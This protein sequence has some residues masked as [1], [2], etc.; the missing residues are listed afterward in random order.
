MAG[1]C[2]SK[3]FPAQ[4]ARLVPLRSG[5]ATH[6]QAVQ[7]APHARLADL[8]VVVALEVYLDLA[9]SEVVALP[10]VDDLLDD[11]DAGGV[12]LGPA[13]LGLVEQAVDAVG[14]IAAEPGV[15]D[16]AADADV[17]AGHGHVPGDFLDVTQY[18][19]AAHLAVRPGLTH[20]QL[21]LIKKP[22]RQASPSVL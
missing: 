1:R 6:V 4:V 8:D 18:R 13:P 22:Q 12:W 14:L 9:G 7:D 16:R 11:F 10:N 5:Q 3:R 20:Q 2:F 21:L 19:Q 17:S 15:V